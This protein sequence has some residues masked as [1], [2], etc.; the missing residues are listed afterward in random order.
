[1]F[2]NVGYNLRPMEISGAIGKC[3]LLRL[4][5]YEREQKRKS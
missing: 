2:V 4:D 3:Q 1:M 5:S